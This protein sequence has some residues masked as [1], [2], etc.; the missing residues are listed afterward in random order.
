MDGYSANDIL[1]KDDFDEQVL[2]V[3]DSHAH[4]LWYDL[5]DQLTEL[6]IPLT[7]FPTPIYVNNFT[8]YHDKYKDTPPKNISLLFFLGRPIHLF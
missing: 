1:N 2:L 7:Y 3:G 8:R 6:N 5:K 4:A